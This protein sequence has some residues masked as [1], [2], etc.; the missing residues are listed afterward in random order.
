MDEKKQNDKR[1]LR[2]PKEPKRM[3]NPRREKPPNRSRR[4]RL[5]P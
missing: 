2:V 1:R 5:S 4:K 3:G